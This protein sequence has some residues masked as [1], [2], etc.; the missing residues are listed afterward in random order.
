MSKMQ[1]TPP[2]DVLRQTFGTHVS[3]IE[4]DLTTGSRPNL[5]TRLLKNCT[6]RD[7]GKGQYENGLSS[8]D[9]ESYFWDLTVGERTSLLISIA[10]PGETQIPLR[11]TCT[12]AG[13]G[14]V[15]EVA[16]DR[17]V[18]LALQQDSTAVNTVSVSKNDR[19]FEY[20]KPSGR[21]QKHWLEKSYSSEMEAARTM[22]STLKVGDEEPEISEEWIEVVNEAMQEIDPLVNFVLSVTCPTCTQ[23]SSHGI[24]LEGIALSR[25]QEKQRH[26]LRTVHTIASQYHWTEEEILSIPDWRR[27]LYISLIDR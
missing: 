16:V 19:I 1:P 21:D 9:S 25:L 7:H 22:I 17:D 13:C 23:D 3:D 18:L 5:V 6:P 27:S 11:L 10:F 12:H 15:M 8:V 2:H 14:E 20:R 24:D 26:L 4:L